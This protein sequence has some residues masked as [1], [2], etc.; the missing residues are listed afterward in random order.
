MKTKT[1]RKPISVTYQV[2][3]TEDV[4][5]KSRIYFANKTYQFKTRSESTCPGDVSDAA[6]EAIYRL[7]GLIKQ[8]TF[9]DF[10]PLA[11]NPIIINVEEV[12]S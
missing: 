6:H 5:N 4:A 3:F 1:N 7:F 8:N 2:V 10:L 9:I 11:S 12:A